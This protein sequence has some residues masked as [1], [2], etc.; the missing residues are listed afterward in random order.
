MREFNTAEEW[1]N[2]HERRGGDI[3][4]HLRTL[5]RLATACD[6]V[7]ELGVRWVCSSWGL[8]LGRPRT[9][10]S[11]DVN[12]VNPEMLAELT[13][14]AGSQ[15]TEFRFVQ[16]NVLNTDAIGETDVLFI[17]TLHA[18][19]QL[20]TELYLHADK[21]RRHIVLHDTVSFGNHDEGKVDLTV[22]PPDLAAL[23]DALPNRQG[24]LAAVDEFLSVHDCWAVSENHMNNNGLMVLSRR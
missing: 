21:A 2:L 17:D 9:L 12:P 18:Y 20:K 24:L 5:G 8:L 10:L 13:R 3:S 15:G 22:L 6:H 19:K 11:I 7:T 23:I 14:I 1:V 16:A 4:E